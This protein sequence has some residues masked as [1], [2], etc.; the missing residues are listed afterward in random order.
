MCNGMTPA[1]G[2]E[3]DVDRSRLPQQIRPPSAVRWATLDEAKHLQKISRVSALTL[4]WHFC[5]SDSY[6]EPFTMG[7]S[8]GWRAFEEIENGLPDGGHA[9]LGGR[10]YD[11]FFF[12][13]LL[14]GGGSG[15][16]RRRSSS[17]RY[18]CVSPSKICL[19]SGRAQAL[20]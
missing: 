11:F 2:G 10:S 6:E 7:A 16:R 3:L 4:L 8:Q 15:G 20:P 1:V 5:F 18:V 12:V 9:G 17:S 14:L 19:R 13:P